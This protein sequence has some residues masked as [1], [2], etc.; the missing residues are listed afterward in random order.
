MQLTQ[1]N[2]SF[3]LYDVNN[4]NNILVKDILIKFNE[5]AIYVDNHPQV[6]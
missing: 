4:V 2:L 1:S 3:S 6:E 5:A